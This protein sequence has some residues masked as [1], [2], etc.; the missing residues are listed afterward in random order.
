MPSSR[1]NM[2]LTIKKIAREL[3]L[4]RD[5]RKLWNSTFLLLQDTFLKIFVDVEFNFSSIL[6]KP[7]Y[8]YIKISDKSKK[9]LQNNGLTNAENHLFKQLSKHNFRHQYQFTKTKPKIHK[10]SY[11]S[12]LYFLCKLMSLSDI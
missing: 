7:L 6:E 9:I 11:L 10:H 12:P 3:D 4:K 8:I 2:F 5:I 1:K